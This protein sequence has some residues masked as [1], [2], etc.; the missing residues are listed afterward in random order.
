MLADV[1]GSRG[2]FQGQFNIGISMKTGNLEI[3]SHSDLTDF[4]HTNVVQQTPRFSIQQAWS[5]ATNYLNILGVNLDKRAVL[6]TISFE[7]SAWS[8]SLWHITWEPCDNGY[9][10]DD[11][12]QNIYH[13]HVTVGINE[14]YGFVLFFS[15][16]FPPP[17]KTTE[18]RIPRETAIFKAEKAVP[19][20]MRTPYYQQCRMPGF[21]AS[22]VK[23]A[24][25]RMACPNWLLDPARAI[26]IW[27][28]PPKET[29]LCWVVRFATVDT[30]KREGGFNPHPPDILVYIDAATGEIVGANF[31]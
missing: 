25:L 30:V 6:K 4:I 28:S 13:P 23:S 2:W 15:A 27:D 10:Y 12:L 1:Y 18:V 21:K 31:T 26:W 3:F 20:V 9:F 22:G 24:D 19:L 29:R 17:P 8:R 7:N 16:P 5:C 11:F 14:E